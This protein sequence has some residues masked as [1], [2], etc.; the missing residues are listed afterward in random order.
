VSVQ[1]ITPDAVVQAV[2]EGH[3][4]VFKLAEHFGVMHVSHTLRS[5]IK[6]LVN[7]GRITVDQ[8]RDYLIEVAS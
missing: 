1:D 3:D 6:E 8:D 7:A 2:Q 4:D 5:T